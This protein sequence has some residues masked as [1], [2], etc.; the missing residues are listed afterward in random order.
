[1]NTKQSPDSPQSQLP[2]IIEGI[3]QVG[4]VIL[5]LTAFCFIL[6]LRDRRAKVIVAQQQEARNRE[7]VLQCWE[8]G[9]KQA[10]IDAHYKC[11]QYLIQDDEDGPLT[12]WKREWDATPAPKK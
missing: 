5:L 1:M 10:I 7:L 12:L 8:A 9:Y 6:D 4:L 11:S 2:K 3:V